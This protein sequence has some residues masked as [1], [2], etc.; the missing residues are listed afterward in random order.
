MQAN[1]V[2]AGAYEAINIK[3]YGDFFLIMSGHGLKS[4]LLIME[5]FPIKL[6]RF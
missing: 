1:I 6:N 3:D 2:S 5:I 4:V